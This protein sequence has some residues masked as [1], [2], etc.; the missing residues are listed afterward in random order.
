MCF[1]VTCQL[2][3]PFCFKLTEAAARDTLEQVMAETLVKAGAKRSAVRAV[4]L[5]V[6]GVNHPTDQERVLNW[7]RLVTWELF[8][9]FIF[10]VFMDM[11]I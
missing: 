3:P 9:N 11:L 8:C 5:G 7:L 10:K 2:P 4:C 1:D 6:S